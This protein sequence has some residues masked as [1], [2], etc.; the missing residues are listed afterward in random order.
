MKPIKFWSLIAVCA[1]LIIG[2][3]VGGA[4]GGVAAVQDSPAMTV[5]IT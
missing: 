3:S 4:V 1:I 2:A 5:T